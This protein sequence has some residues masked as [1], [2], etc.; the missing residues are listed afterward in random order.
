MIVRKAPKHRYITK[1]VRRMFTEET[2]TEEIIE[3]PMEVYNDENST[4]SVENNNL[5]TDIIKPN[6]KMQ[7]ICYNTQHLDKYDR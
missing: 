1:L 5:Y 2:H 4:Y 7:G 6:P 3:D